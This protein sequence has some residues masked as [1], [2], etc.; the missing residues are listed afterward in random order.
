MVVYLDVLFVINALMDGATLL[1]AARLG[2]VAI[3]RSRLLIASLLGGGY[4][5]LAAVQPALAALPLRLL[6][7]A[8]LCAA[9]LGTR[10][11]FGR[12]CALYFVTAGC[13]AG[14]AAALGA[15]TGRRLFYGAG[16]YFAVPMR[17]L[18]LAAALAYAV[19]GVLLRGDAMHGAVRGEVETFTVRFGGR[20]QVLRV[21]HDTGNELTEPVSGRPVLVLERAAACA[22]LGVPSDADTDAASLLASLPQETA[23]R[24]GLLPFCAVG[25]EQGLLL[26]FRPDAVQRASGRL[27]CVCAVGPANLGRGAYEGLI[28]E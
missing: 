26:Y 28:G 12:I 20:E 2:G 8:G 13:F 7:G 14:F 5:V 16:Y 18:V 17:T 6:A 11:H 1:A 19:S 9:G 23:R 3:R 25:T 22:L 15:M 24:C 27:D 4:A 21:L 10:A